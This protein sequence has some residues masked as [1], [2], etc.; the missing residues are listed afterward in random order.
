[1]WLSDLKIALIRKD[2]PSL[3]RLIDTIPVMTDQSERK[4]AAYLLQ[5]AQ[6][7]FK[8]LK[9]STARSM[10]QT[11]KSIDF[12]RSTQTETPSSLDITL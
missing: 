7:L 2:V 1:M 5:E 10:A 6:L 12:L 3:I 11:K 9:E 8:T 4:E